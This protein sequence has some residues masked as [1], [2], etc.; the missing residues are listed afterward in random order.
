MPCKLKYAFDEKNKNVVIGQD[1]K[2]PQQDIDIMW[3]NKIKEQTMFLPKQHQGNFGRNNHLSNKEKNNLLRMERIQKT[4][5][6]W[7][8]HKKN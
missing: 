4:D 3:K 7:N 6:M 2:P 8:T 5:E 1:T